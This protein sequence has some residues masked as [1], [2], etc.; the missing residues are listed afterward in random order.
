MRYNLKSSQNDTATVTIYGI[1]FVVK[2]D[3]QPAEPM[4]WEEP[5]CDEQYDVWEIK[6]A[7]MSDQAAMEGEEITEADLK[8]DWFM[9]LV[10]IQLTEQHRSYERS[11]HS[12]Y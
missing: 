5:G 7:T 12:N 9:E 10:E 11:Y 2:F 4:T 8:S 6:P 1:N 3:Y